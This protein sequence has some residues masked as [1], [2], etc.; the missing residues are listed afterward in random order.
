MTILRVTWREFVAGLGGTAAWPLVA[1]AQQAMPVIG[2]LSGA[3]LDDMKPAVAV[4]R[5]GLKEAGYIEGK[6]VVIEYRWAQNKIERLPELAADLVRQ[7]VT[8]IVAAGSTPAALA[9]KT[10][11]PQFQSCSVSVA[12]RSE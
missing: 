8:V 6:N 3:S 1:R 2:F 5:Q 12:T 7:Q 4:F 9:A 11:Q 10:L